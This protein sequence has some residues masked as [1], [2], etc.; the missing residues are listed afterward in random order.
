M[1]MEDNKG[2]LR[3]IREVN[4]KPYLVKRVKVCRG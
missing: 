2:N 4:L 1:F 3:Y